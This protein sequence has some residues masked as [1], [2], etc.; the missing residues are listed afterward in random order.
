M[1]RVFFVAFV[2]LFASPLFGL[3]QNYSG[4]MDGTE[5]SSILLALAPKGGFLP[6]PAV[7]AEDRLERFH[8]FRLMKLSEMASEAG[9]DDKT[10]LKISDILKKYDKQRFDLFEEGKRLKTE[11]KRLMDDK[12]AKKEDINRTIDRFLDNRQKI[13]NLKIEEINE[14]R[15]LLTPEQQARMILFMTERFEK[16]MRHIHKCDPKHGMGPNGVGPNMGHGPHISP[17]M[18][19]CLLDDENN[20]L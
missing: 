9:I 16:G 4:P 18:G 6:P 11:L 17:P 8:K 10:I 20:Y 2:L 19:N 14:I 12:N 7:D 1:K 5:G 13:H 3:S 15:R